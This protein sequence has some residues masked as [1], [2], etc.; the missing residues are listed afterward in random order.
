MD[1]TLRDAGLAGVCLLLLKECVAL[2]MR[3]FDGNKDAERTHAI[4]LALMQLANAV[5]N[6]SKLLEESIKTQNTLLS[7]MRR[8]LVDQKAALAR[9]ETRQDR[10][11]D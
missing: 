7:D 10:W 3:M 1:D 2:I 11:R 6:Q 8:E 9:L 5:N 4:E